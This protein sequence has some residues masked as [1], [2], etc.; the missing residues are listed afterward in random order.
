MINDREIYIDRFARIYVLAIEQ[1]INLDLINEVL[2][3]SSLIANIERDNYSELYNN[4]IVSLVRYYFDCVP[5]EDDSLYKFN[6]AYWCG[7]VYMNIFYQYHKPFSYIFLKLPLKKLIDMYDVY[8]EM[9]I[10]AIYEIFEELSKQK[11]I[12]Q[13]LLEKHKINNKKLAK[14]SGVKNS[15]IVHMKQKDDYLYAGSFANVHRIALALN[16]PDNLFLKNI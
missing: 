1:R 9:D 12:L 13:L 3:R 2:A 14:L 16:E 8:H 10:I 4:S 5:F 6:N 15:T 7:F 11:T